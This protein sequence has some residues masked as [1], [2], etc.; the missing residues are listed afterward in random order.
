MK[1][2]PVV[3]KICGMRNELNV[4]AVAALQ[5]D[6]MGFIFYEASPR[7]VG[8]QFSVPN[9]FPASIKRVGV[10]VNET[11]DRVQELIQ[12]HR[13]DFVQL[14]GDE[15]VVYAQNL[16]SRVGVIKVFRVDEDFDFGST[17][18]Y[19]SSVDFFLFDTKGKHYG[20]NAKQ[21]DWNLLKKYTGTTPFFL[22]GGISAATVQDLKKLHHEKFYGIDIN[23][24]VEEQPAIKSVDKIKSLLLS[25][26]EI[27]LK[28]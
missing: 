21:F 2:A 26:N 12:K 11:I 4:C 17:A 22:S 28:H 27:G 6:Y 8:H 18:E 24:G 20:G 25:L 14:H 5:P 15:S 16:K 3:W 23:S 7:F 9:D 1:L 13:L 10:F 19:E